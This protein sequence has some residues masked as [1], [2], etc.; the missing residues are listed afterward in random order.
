VMAALIFSDERAAQ[1]NAQAMQANPEL[2]AVGVY[3]ANG[4]PFA[5]YVRPGAAA[6]PATAVAKSARFEGNKLVVTLPVLQGKATVGFVYLRAMTESAGRRIARFSGILLLV[7]MAALVLIVFATAQTSLA[8]A[9]E[10]LERRA[11]DL[12]EANRKLQIEMDE[13][14]RAEEALRQSQKMEAI[15]QLSGGIAHDFNNLLTIVMGSLSLLQRRIQQ[16]RTDIERYVDSAME[17]LK[18]AASL[19]QRILAFSRRQPLSPKSVDL[20]ALI[21]AMTDLVRHSVGERIQIKFVLAA[22]WVVLCDANQMENVVLNLAINARD[23]MPSG[24]TVEIATRNEHVDSP[25]AEFS[26]APPGDYVRLSVSDTGVGMSE[27]TRQKA[28]DP[29]FTTKPPGQGTGLGLS[30]TFGYI[31]QSGGFMNIQSEVGRG[32][33]VEILM[34]RHAAPAKE[35][36]A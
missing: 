33:T 5:A 8:R 12:A 31:R 27:E 34:P 6:L 23:A 17:G 19:T 21:V 28:I 24:G 36:A 2:E 20:S 29:F 25:L 9:N 11:V 10:E 22:D 7:I 4:R 30:M 1:E 26:D 15:G 3:E 16:G 35:I 32:T 13:R 14:S 18:R